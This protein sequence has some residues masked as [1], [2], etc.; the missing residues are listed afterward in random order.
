MEWL[1]DLHSDDMLVLG[2]V[3]TVAGLIFGALARLA[4]AGV[5][6]RRTS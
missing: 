1:H 6:N 2:S 5:R 3:A 4:Y